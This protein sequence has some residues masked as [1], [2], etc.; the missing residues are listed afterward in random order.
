MRD[1]PAGRDHTFERLTSLASKARKDPKKVFF[2]GYFIHPTVYGTNAE[3]C[4]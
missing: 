1:R 2:G 3:S 4:Q